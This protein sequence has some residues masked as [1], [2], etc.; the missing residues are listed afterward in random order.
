MG[1][2]MPKNLIPIADAHC[3]F[4][5]HMAFSE[6][7]IDAPIQKDHH[8][9]KKGLLTGG[10]AVQV[11]AIWVDVSRK[12]F[13]DDATKMADSFKIMVENTPEI[14][15]IKKSKDFELLKTGEN[16]GAILSVEG[17]GEAIEGDLL[18][19]KE[20]YNK[21]ARIM[22]FTWNNENE[23]GYGAWCDENEG[24]KEKGIQAIKI[25]NDLNVA[26]DVSH[27]NTK[28]FWDIVEYSKSP[29]IATHSNVHSLFTSRRNLYD[30]QIQA[31]IDMKGHI[32]VSYYP[33]FLGK[34]FVNV[35]T[36]VQNIDFICSLGGIDCVGLGS[37][38]DGMLK[39]PTGLSGSQ[40]A[41]SIPN[42]LAKLNYTEEQIKK[43]C[44][45]NFINYIVNFL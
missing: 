32:G 23:L 15:H 16:V 41:Q 26:I 21:G 34:R 13:Y 14:I 17:L 44:S 5:Y 3:D 43:I 38:F 42:E 45:L 20:F 24:L 25:L 11:F 4:L 12:S 40:H 6:R 35:K 1:S 31:I 37:D 30:D 8:I 29:I 22:S 27:I 10:Y 36:V 19:I 18:R 33:P 39:T 9:T 2:V 7:N 28:G